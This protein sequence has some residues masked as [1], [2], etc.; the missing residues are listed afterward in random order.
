MCEFSES[1]F[2]VTAANE[3]AAVTHVT[4]RGFPPSRIERNDDG[5]SVLVFAP[6][7]DDRMS[8]LA[9]ALPVHLSAKIAIVGGPLFE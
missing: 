3:A 8:G 2:S 1:Y 5:I 6:L 4:A 7:P 9:Q